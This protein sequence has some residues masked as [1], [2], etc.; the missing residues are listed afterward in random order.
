MAG[1]RQE[2]VEL[3]YEM[4]EEL[5]SGQF[6]IVRKCKEKSTGVEYAAKFIKKRRLS[7]SRRGVSREEIE[8]EVN[9]LREIQHSNIITLHDIFEN[10]TDVILILE[11]VSGGELFDFLAE[12]ESLTEEEATQFLKQILDGVHYLHSKRIAHFDLKPE[13]IMLLDKNVPNP[14]IK[15]IDFGIAHQIKAGNEFK[16][17]FGTP[18]FV[19]PEI[20]NYE[21]LGLEADMWS[22]G[23]ITYILLSGASPFLGETKQE[24]LTN[25]SA[26]NYDFDEEYF[27]NTSEL[28]KDFIR[29]L[30]VKDPKKR[31]TIDESLQHPWIKVIKRR[32]V[33]Q[34]DRDHKTERR[35]LKTTR[36]KEYTIKSHSSMPPNNT[37]VNFERFS[38]V[39]E[40]I[41]AAEEGLRELE[42]NQRSCQE[43]VAALLSIYEEKEGWYKEE[44]QSISADLSHIRQELQ[45]TQAQRRKCQEDARQTMQNANTLK[46]KF[47][48]LENRYEVLAE[49]VASEVRWVEELLKSMSAEDGLGSGSMP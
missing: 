5:G 17:I 7:S 6:A 35:R 25:I 20:V 11:L 15:L 44:N 10:K 14:R 16:N 26:V 38:Q 23:V 42:R 13:N 12:K 48:R 37:Y 3:Y 29:R 2:D 1:F 33:R 47:G 41:A 24:T 28:A 36:L 46:R 27:S 34:E 30:L 18:E 45:R 8:R 32:N 4:G 39:L 43:D 40:E 22:I 31:M 49:Q 21:P 9:I 19:A